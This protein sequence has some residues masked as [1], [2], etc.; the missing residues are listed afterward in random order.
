M[1]IIGIYCKTRIFRLPIILVSE[2]RDLGEFA[3]ITGANMIFL[4]YYFV[5]QSKNAKLKGA[6]II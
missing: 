4:V 3:K 5:Q 2:F 1:Q 6:K